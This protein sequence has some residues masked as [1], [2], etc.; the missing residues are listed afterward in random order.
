M[1]GVFAAHAAKRRAAGKAQ[2]IRPPPWEVFRF[3]QR[4]EQ[5]VHRKHRLMRI[6]PEH[7]AAPRLVRSFDLLK[8]HVPGSDETSHLLQLPALSRDGFPAW[9]H[10]DLAVVAVAYLLL[11]PRETV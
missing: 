7:R 10:D 6:E 2:L 8:G 1:S 5:R 9:A 3:E 11:Q 4:R